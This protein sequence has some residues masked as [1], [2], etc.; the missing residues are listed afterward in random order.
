VDPARSKSVSELHYAIWTEHELTVAQP[1]YVSR[2]C[3]VKRTRCDE[4]SSI[5]YTRSSAGNAHDETHGHD[6]QAHEDKRITL[7][8]AITEPRHCD[9]EYR[10]S[11]VDWHSQKLC[12]RAG[13]SEA[14]NNGGKEERDAVKRTDDSCISH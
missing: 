9:C 10:S 6:T 4:Y 2:E 11:D 8:Y 3:R 7:S 5:D 14:S 13:V 12:S 1:R